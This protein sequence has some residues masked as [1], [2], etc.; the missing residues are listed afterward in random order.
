MDH[1]RQIFALRRLY[2][3]QVENRVAIG[4]GDIRHA[5]RCIREN[6]GIEL[7]NLKILEIGP[8]QFGGQL[9]FLALN[10]QAIGVDTDIVIHG[11]SVSKYFQMFRQNGAARTVKTIGRK[12]MGVDRRYFKELRTKLS[13]SRISVPEIRTANAMDLPF[14]ANEFDFVYSRAV[15]QCVPEPIRAVREVKRVL[16]PG[17]I[18]FITLQPYTS[19]TG[20]LDPR[21]L[22]GGINNE[23][24]L[25]PHLRDELKEKVRPNS[26]VNK[27]GLRDWQ[28]IF[29]DECGGPIFLMTGVSEEYISLAN[30][31]KGA[32]HLPDYSV[33]ELTTGAL[34]VLF[35]RTART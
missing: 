25:W 10:N 26:Y 34:D 7:R 14:D 8:G 24:G 4:L 12:L 28:R 22:Y 29:R 11:F 32:G 1:L 21:V 3:V 20:C 5:E 35:T 13:V 33:E 31:L 15:F 27:L 2:S 18:A 23:L 30:E 16:K 17:G 19:P 6:Y 9:P